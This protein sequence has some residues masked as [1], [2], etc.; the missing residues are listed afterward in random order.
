M[1]KI[2]DMQVIRL[3][4][5]M[6]VFYAVPLVCADSVFIV[7]HGTWGLESEWYMPGGDFFDAL[8]RTVST[9]NSAVVPF[10]W[11]GG[12][13]HESRVKAAHS[14]AKLIAAYNDDVALYLIAHSHGGNVAAIA[15]QILACDGRNKRRIRALYTLGTPVMSNYLP[16]MD[17]ITYLYSFF[18]LEDLVQ[19]VL[20][21]SMREYPKHKRIANLRVFIDGK[22]PGHSGLHDGVVGQWL[23]LIHQQFKQYLH[24]KNVFNTIAEPSIIYFDYTKAPEFVHDTE[25]EALMARDRQLS[26]LMLSSL[27]NSFDTGSK[28][29][30]T[31]R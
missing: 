6:I 8:E 20:G 26:V 16:N 30:L 15:S 4:I 2:G 3:I 17:V 24:K 28:I 21:V 12:I 27:R 29:P 19:P 13:G 23:P 7:I 11:N 9:K 10:C 25:R 5:F 14:L 31:K 18:S 22:E 1:I